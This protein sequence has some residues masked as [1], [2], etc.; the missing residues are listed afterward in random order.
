MVGQLGLVGYWPFVCF[1]VALEEVTKVVH[2]F[3][4]STEPQTDLNLYAYYPINILM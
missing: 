3:R 1:V 2:M 4:F